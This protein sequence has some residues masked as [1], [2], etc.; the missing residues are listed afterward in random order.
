MGLRYVAPFGD[1][2]RVYTMD[3]DVC[4]TGTLAECEAHVAHINSL[5]TT[6][7]TFSYRFSPLRP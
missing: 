5:S 3:G 2:F 1:L 7:E 4:M 6:G